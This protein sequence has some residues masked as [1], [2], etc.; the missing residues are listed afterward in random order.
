M[1]SRDYG[2]RWLVF[3][4]ETQ[5]LREPVGTE[6]VDSQVRMP[7]WARNK[8]VA[9]PRDLPISPGI[10]GSESRRG[11]SALAWSERLRCAGP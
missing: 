8:R 6:E 7:P 3:D 10:F 5:E 4:E 1:S 9:H 2:H 11:Y